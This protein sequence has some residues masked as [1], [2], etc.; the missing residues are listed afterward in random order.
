[1]KIRLSQKDVDVL[2]FLG[3]Y[4]MML[5]SDCKMIYQANDYHR[6]RLKVLEK[7]RYI[8]RVKRIYIK[9]DDKGTKLVR[10]FGYD[11]SFNCR[12]SEYIERLEKIAKVAS[13]TINSDI[14][15][16]ASWELKDSSIFTE[17]SRKYLGELSVLNEKRIV[18][19]IS[20]NKQISYISK[21]KND[22][23]KLINYSNIIIFIDNKK[24][25]ERANEFLF[26]KDSLVFIEANQENL[27]VLRILDKVDSH[28]IVTSI[29]LDKEILLS[30][31]KLADY[32][33][34]DENYIV[35]MPFIDIERIYAL[36]LFYNHNPNLINKISIVTLKDNQSYIEKDLSNKVNV[37]ALNSW[38]GGL[39]DKEM[40]C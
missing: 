35:F 8:R 17:T 4:K 3:K 25:L 13:L 38:L 32:M 40:E 7:N 6:K 20:K 2:M 31:W 15:F 37:I 9:L 10:D 23:Q 27:D 11:Y 24:I 18:Y 14:E 22:I 30:N 36:N 12:K 19:Y 34:I 29:F 5:A 39:N 26:G 1:M 21:I 33:T 28:K 16:I